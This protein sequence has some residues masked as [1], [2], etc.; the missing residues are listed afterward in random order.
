M[1]AERGHA[2]LAGHGIEHKLA[3]VYCEAPRTGGLTIGGANFKAK[4]RWQSLEIADL[5]APHTGA[6]DVYAWGLLAGGLDGCFNY[7]ETDKVDP[8]P[9]FGQR[10]RL[11][12]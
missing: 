8:Q 6:M 1:N 3:L 4:I 2:I 5:V 12:N 9:C 7:V 11:E 10:E